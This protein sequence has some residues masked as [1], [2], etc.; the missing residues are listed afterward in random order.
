V[1]RADSLSKVPESQ[2]EKTYFESLVEVS[3]VAI[4]VMDA[5]ERVTNWNPAAA[6]LFGWSAD[7]AV[8]RLIDDLVLSDEL[9]EE[10]RD[11]TR[12]ALER[13]RADRI[14]RR[15]R[16]DGELVDVQMMLVPLEL[17]G[18]HV[19]FH[20]IYHDITELQ[21]AREQAETLLAVTQVLG[22]TL[23]L[24]DTIEAI[25][26]EL[27][28]VVPYDSCSVQVIQGDRLVI[29][30]ARGLDDLGGLM[31]VAF[32]LTD[33]TNLNSHVVRS[34]RQQF[35]ADVSENPHFASDIH[36]G[37]RIRGWI[38]APM[39]IGDRVIGVLSIDKFEPDVYNEELAELATAFA[40]QA[41]TAIENARLLETEREAREQAETLRA[42][43]QTL[44]STLGIHQVFDL[45]LS[46]LRKVVPYRSASVQQLD[47]DEFV[48]VGGQGYPD[49]DEL[50]GHRYRWT[51]P[52]DPA[53]ELVER[54]ETLIVPDV[55]VRYRQGGQFED[56]HGDGVIKSWMAVPLLI[57]DRLMGM[58]TLDS[59]EED[60]Y[61]AEHANMAKAFAAFAATA[62]DKARFVSELQRAREEAELAAEA[63]SVFL[64]SMSHEIRTPMNA[65]IGMSGLLL[66]TELDAEQ[67]E[68]AEIIRTSSEALLTIINDILDFS[69][70][71][72][73][74]MELESAPFDFRACVDGV[75][76]LI[77]SLASAKGLE[78]SSEIDDGVPQTIVG[79][80]GR[81]RQI[82]LNVLNNAVKF[83]ED[84]SIA[85]TVTASP[86]E[87]DGDIE[88][89]LT[90]RDTGI[91]VSADGLERLFQS[92]SQADVSI[93]RRYGGTGLGLAISKRLAEA[94]GGT[95]WAESDGVAGQ[96]ST[97][98]VT[99]ATRATADAAA[100]ADTT[101]DSSDLDPE[102]ATRHPLRILLAEDNAVNQKLALRLFSL[103][104]YQADVAGN[105]IEALE[106][107]ERQPY[108]VVFMDVQMP[109]MDGLEATR[110][111]RA[112]LPDSP[113]IV[114]MTANAMDGD[115]EAC[116]EAG[117]DDYVSKPIR[118][119]ELVAALEK[120]PAASG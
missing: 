47:G 110:R 9:R 32:D 100:G 86:A 93:N 17:E 109:E 56:V 74:R 79:D 87:A 70:I 69:K 94:M 88:L 30:G 39:I 75:L 16:K 7:E 95:M 80:V 101:P 2:G 81:V 48:I 102:R 13:G 64:A 57:G 6:A 106:A 55:S 4:V 96:G 11:V 120:T 33:E 54:H 103:M 89:H 44:G 73:G 50:L 46:E 59:F 105:G 12:E 114:A 58:L 82:L 43:A 8:G 36:G 72:A 14:T 104:G 42:A 66:R 116:L 62:I 22:K 85:L 15:A 24:E 78:L 91:G 5:D 19:G 53:R 83:T 98:H 67:R 60:F 27:Q 28:R 71:E 40:A 76:A 92:F 65:V 25:L 97:F 63:K 10:G 68:S 45:I 115:R 49:L 20:A 18:E 26:G 118:I 35:F 21:R 84:G 61:T 29:V 117:M 119:E 108:D 3:P 34:R 31:G 77:G 1:E 112:A 99:F 38:C 51:G 52:N 23:S 41:A 107:V 90:V 111:I 37:G 113:R